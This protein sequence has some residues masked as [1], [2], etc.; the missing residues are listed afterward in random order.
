MN[1]VLPSELL[2]SC[3]SGS[4]RKSIIKARPFGWQYCGGVYIRSWPVHLALLVKLL[5]DPA[6]LANLKKER[7]EWCVFGKCGAFSG[8]ERG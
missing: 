4:K 6:G 3:R 2:P 5:I 7:K 1:A 8:S